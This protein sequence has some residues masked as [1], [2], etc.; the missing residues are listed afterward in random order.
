M[1]KNVPHLLVLPEDDA[2]RQLA[3]GFQKDPL[4]DLRRMQILEVAGG[5]LKVLEVFQSEHTAEMAKYANRFMVLLIDFD[6]K[7][8]RLHRAKEKIPAN[9]KDRVFI[10]GSWST[11]EELRQNLGSYETIGSA[12][13][14]DC[15]NDTRETWADPLL[16]HNAA[17][18]DRLQKIVRPFLFRKN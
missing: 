11:P 13:A 14:K 5:W 10:L 8:E 18:L 15:R 2:N 12:A 17:E 1:N 3:N 6:G 4:L 9:L 7:E 16:N